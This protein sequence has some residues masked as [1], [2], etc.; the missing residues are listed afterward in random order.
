[1]WNTFLAKGETTIAQ[2]MRNNGYKTGM[3]GKYH[4]FDNESVQKYV[5][6]DAD[7]N[8]AS[9]RE[10]MVQNYKM[11]SSEIR[12]TAGFDY[13]E[14]IYAN[15]LHAVSIPK[16]MQFHNMEWITKGALDFIKQ[17][18]TQPFFLYMASTIPHGPS[19]L[20][21][22]KSDPRITPAGYLNS[23][24][25]VQPSREDVFRRVKEAGY[26][27]LS[28]P[29]TW[30]DDAVGAVLNKLEKLRLTENTMIILASDHG[31]AK[32]KMTCYEG[33][34]KAP[35][36]V[37]YPQKFKGGYEINEVTSN[38]DLAPTILDVCGITF[39]PEENFDGRSIKPL[40]KGKKSDWRKSLYL[41]AAYSKG[42]V[43]E[44][45]KY[46]AVRYPKKI[47]EQITAENRKEF[48]QEGM[49]SMVDAVAGK[50]N[51]RY[52]ADE[53]YPGYFDDDQLYNLKSDPFEKNNLALTVEYAEKLKEMK[54]I[55]QKYSKT[56]PHR[57]GEFGKS[58][59]E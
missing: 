43:T 52:K 4:L 30:L 28:A 1:R 49:R 8:D 10:I 11:I 19:P 51:V 59:K 40:L 25:R 54:Q 44:N 2:I 46:I 31:S 50:V 23:P 14:S 15:N 48:N 17:N 18:S 16:S 55:F 39:K 33:G 32:G 35:A 53:D 57:F 37:W 41:E 9:V 47:K 38:I 29:V 21:S 56:L 12:K 20:S 45:W 34:A 36:I 27:E 58:G 22:M 3:V 42:V 24:P 26:N 13:A 6:P 5:A 7:P